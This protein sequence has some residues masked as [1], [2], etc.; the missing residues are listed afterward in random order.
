MPASASE[1]RMGEL[2]ASPSNLFGF[3]LTSSGYFAGC[4]GLEGEAAAR[5]AETRC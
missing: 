5:R 2:S 3:P 4:Q 1:L